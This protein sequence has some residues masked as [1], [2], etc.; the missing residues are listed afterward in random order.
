M[1]VSS[2]RCFS[3]DNLTHFTHTHKK[4]QAGQLMALLFSGSAFG[5]TQTTLTPAMLQ[6]GVCFIL[7]ITA[8]HLH[9]ESEMRKR[10]QVH[11][12]QVDEHLFKTCCCTLLWAK[13]PDWAAFSGINDVS[14]ILLCLLIC[15]KWVCI[16]GIFFYFIFN[17]H[18]NFQPHDWWV[19]AH[20]PNDPVVHVWDHRT[21]LF[22]WLWILVKPYVCFFFFS[23]SLWIFHF[24]Y[25]P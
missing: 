8:L 20:F 25:F 11:E 5:L 15:C 3:D 12:S 9:R 21:I 10:S 7:R 24:L 13:G 18:L 16:R 4:N 23:L 1:S 14:F 6:L 22:L 19:H 17:Y 2:L